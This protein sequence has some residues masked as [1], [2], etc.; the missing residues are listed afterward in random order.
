MLRLA[1][2]HMAKLSLKI[3]YNIVLI[4]L[5]VVLMSPAVLAYENNFPKLANYYL[6]SDQK[7]DWYKLSQ[8]DLVILPIDTQLYS[9]GFFGFARQHNPDIIILAY[10]PAQ[11]VNISALG[12]TRSFNYKLNQQI[13]RDWYLYDSSKNIISTWP[14]LKNT[15]VTT[16]W[17]TWF[18]EFVKANVLN[19]NLWDGIF[20][21][22]VDS[23]ISWANNGD[24][25][26]NQDWKKDNPNWVNNQWKNGMAKLLNKSRQIFGDK[27]IVIN[28]SSVNK[29]QP[30][31]NGRMFEDFPTPW[32][33]N[34]SWSDSMNA[35][36]ANATQTMQPNI[37]ILNSL[38]NANDYKKMRF[39]LTSSLML[40]AYFGHD[41]S[42]ERHEAMWHFDE[43]DTNLGQ[44]VGTVKNLIRADNYFAPGVW[45]RNF[46]HGIA[47]VNS[48]NQSQTINLD[49]VY[50]K[51]RGT[52]DA[53][54]NNGE[55][56]R[57]VTLASNDGIILLN[58]FELQTDSQTLL[59]DVT[60][61]NGDYVRVFDKR[62]QVK[63]SGFYAYDAHFPG[64]SQ[65][66]I[67]DLNNDGQNEIIVAN[68][69]DIKIYNSNNILIN[70]F[71]PYGQ[72]YSR[73]IN[74]AVGNVQGDNQ[75]EIITGTMNGA[76]PEVK[77]FDNRGNVIN[78]G[79]MAYA[80]DFYG[81]VQVTLGDLNGNGYQEIVV[82]AGNGGGPHV[83]IFDY[84]GHL[85]DPGFFPY[86]SNFRG[87]V[88][89][90]C[91]DLNYDGKDEIITGAG[92]GGGPHIRI[93]DKIGHLVDPG[94]FA[95]DPVKR[96]GVRAGAIDVDG[97]GEVEILG[98]SL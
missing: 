3:L 63:R 58:K 62:G 81:G 98:M 17:S 22:M 70:S 51:I 25:D 85:F 24:I 71:Y 5:C 96:D 92:V 57:K 52:Q 97:D 91:A 33:G 43:Y 45:Q 48:T 64:G 30:N 36:K 14:G 89:V 65:I 94:F 46:E 11:S 19:T 73:G 55:L 29:Y 32:Q 15:N 41:D 27:H 34:G 66:V 20:Y 69:S 72:N 47:L 10:T 78:P 80:P 83:R 82:G 7:F 76:Q 90:T 38:G 86:D 49:N 60:F 16:S 79:W 67:T 61:I 88:N 59:T 53:N 18:P 84:T 26:L 23:K 68:K 28:G 13:Q 56:V 37:F 35:L 40:G 50:E 44:A 42:I 75:K 9:R 93:Y 1:I 4:S 54:I 21:D 8:Y 74:L 39:G 77:V 31:I 6:T 95:F 2:K 12:D 87:G